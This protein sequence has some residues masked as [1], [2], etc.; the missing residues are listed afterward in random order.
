MPDKVDFDQITRK[1]LQ[2]EFLQLALSRATGTFKNNRTRAAADLGYF[3]EL[4]ERAKEAKD[5]ALLNLDVYLPRLEENVRARGG[6]VAYARDGREVIEYILNLAREKG[7]KTVVKGKSMTTEEIYLNPAL[8]AAGLEVME[9]DLGEYIIQLV[10]ERPSHIIGPAIHKTKEEIGRLFE[11]KIGL[12]YTDQPEVM[13]QAVRVKLR[14]KFLDADLGITGANFA[15]AETG[16]IV[17][18]ENEGNIRM[19]TTLPKVHVVVMGLEK[20]VADMEDLSS[21]LRILPLSAVGQRLPSYV[22]FL[23]GPGRREGEGPEELHLIILDGFRSK[24]LADPDFRQILRCLRCGACLNFCPVYA[25]LGG[26]SYPWVYSGPIG[27]VLTG[28]AMGAEAA[29]NVVASST[30]CQACGQVCPVKIELPS[31]ILKLR[32]RLARGDRKLELLLSVA[33]K[34]LAAPLG[35]DL[36]GR[37]AG[38]ASR[39]VLDPDGAVRRGPEVLKNTGQGRCLPRLAEEPFHRSMFK[40]NEK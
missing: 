28:A 32:Q 2:N 27:V 10:G 15:V 34:V 7:L 12:P 24:V 29:A 40:G 1:A 20:V 14:Q 5:R 26:H 21:L 25:R 31:L 6:Q 8:E 35:F 23:T 36:A 18:L 33:G 22:S 3:E 4:R 9:T 11:E 13:T 16:T 19:S 17:L 37:A 39:V 38:K 30:L